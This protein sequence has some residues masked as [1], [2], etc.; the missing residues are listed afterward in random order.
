MVQKTPHPLAALYL[1]D[2]TDWLDRNA[3]LIRAGQFDEID[4][5][6]LAEY[7]TDMAIRDRREVVSRLRVLLAH[8]LKWEHQPSQRTGSW[9]STIMEQRDDLRDILESAVLRRHV[10]DVF[11]KTYAKAR[12]LASV[13]TGLALNVFPAEC[14]WDLD[15][16]L[17]DDDADA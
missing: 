1:A 17:K 14:P 3:E 11:V 15:Q 10:E 12:K 7:L 6:T 13:E 8:L 2:E 4:P 9:R 16:I 5:E